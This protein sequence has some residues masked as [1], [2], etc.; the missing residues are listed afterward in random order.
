MSNPI[1]TLGASRSTREPAFARLVRLLDM[2]Q[3]WMRRH[4]DRS[5]LAGLS[6]HLVRDIGLSRADVEN[7]ASKPFWRA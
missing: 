4:E 1:H 7:E 2:V 3:V 6:D 5:R